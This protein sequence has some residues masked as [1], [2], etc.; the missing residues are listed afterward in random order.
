MSNVSYLRVRDTD[1]IP[2][3][4]DLK[5]L[6]KQWR[7]QCEPGSSTHKRYVHAAAINAEHA[8]AAYEQVNYAPL[9]ANYNA[10]ELDAHIRQRIQ[11]TALEALRLLEDLITGRIPASIA[12]R[13]KYAHLHLGRAGYGV[14]NK[15]STTSLSQHLTRED[16]EQL[17]LRASLATQEGSSEPKE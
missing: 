11:T 17:K 6:G 2:I 4:P 8:D 14:I 15:T 5:E 7:E 1:T 9:P 16:I 3:T 12:L 10:A 13:A